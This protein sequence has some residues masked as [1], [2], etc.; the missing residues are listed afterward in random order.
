MPADVLK[1]L[2]NLQISKEQKKVDEKIDRPPMF[3]NSI[4]K[5]EEKDKV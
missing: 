1:D 2:Q 3:I 5:L 4:F